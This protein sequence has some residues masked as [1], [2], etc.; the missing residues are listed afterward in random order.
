MEYKVDGLTFTDKDLDANFVVPKIGGISSAFYF[1]IP[2]H[3][4][5]A[6]TL[7]KPG[8]YISKEIGSR[9]GAKQTYSFTF[10]DNQFCKELEEALHALKNSTNQIE[11]IR[12]GLFLEKTIMESF[13]GS[14]KIGLSLLKTFFEEFYE[15][16]PKIAYLLDQ[17]SEVLF[18]RS[19]CVASF[20]IIY[21]LRCGIV[22]FNFLKKTFNVLICLDIGLVLDEELT[23]NTLVACELER[24]I[25]GQGQEFI[26]HLSI[27][28]QDLFLSH[29]Q[30]GVDF[31]SRVLDQ[32]EYDSVVELVGGHHQYG[33]SSGFPKSFSSA[34]LT[35]FEQIVLFCDSKIPF[36][37]DLLE[38]QK[39]FKTILNFLMNEKEAA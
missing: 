1:F 37:D 25:S 12:T 34:E 9:L 11:R 33:S 31:L 20:S 39:I 6:F 36:I 32:D 22:D 26:K 30:K 8:Q 17:K 24:K 38:S 14:L 21:S 4:S 35:N 27:K 10:C 7:L 18:Q 29:P 23:S 19:L 3:S 13:D 28:E 2:K 5:K 15:M 16:N